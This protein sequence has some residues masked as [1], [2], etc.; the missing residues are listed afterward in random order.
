MIAKLNLA[1]FKTDYVV[2]IQ[3][4]DEQHRSFFEMLD[5]IGNVVSDMYK[6]LSEEEAD[7]L[8]DVIDELREYA[9][10]HFRT[11]ESYMKEV[12]YPGLS[13]Q[14]KEHNRFI[15]D[16]IRM[17]AEIVNGTAMPAIKIRNFMHDWYRDH[18][19]ALDKPFS[20][21]YNKNKN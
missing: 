3:E 19:L 2:D 17:E 7:A 21:F 13:K 9:L 16:V 10:I 14:K 1:G 20:E 15:T 11:E 12:D 4:I 6:P 8:A 5:K 18:I